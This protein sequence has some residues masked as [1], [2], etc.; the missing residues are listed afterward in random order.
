MDI[1]SRQYTIESMVLLLLMTRKEVIN[2]ENK[3][4][5]K[6]Y[7]IQSED[8]KSTKDLMM[9][10]RPASPNPHWNKARVL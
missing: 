4:D 5:R 3:L 1:I 8:K 10:P 6:K 9:Q 7:Q 2:G